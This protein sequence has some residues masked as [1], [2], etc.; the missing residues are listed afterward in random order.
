MQNQFEIKL[1]G[2]CCWRAKT[3]CESKQNSK[4]ISK[5]HI[6]TKCCSPRK[7]P[8]PSLKLFQTCWL[9]ADFQKIPKTT[10]CIST[11]GHTWWKQNW[12]HPLVIWYK[13]QIRN[14]SCSLQ[15]KHSHSTQGKS[16][17]SSSRI[18]LLVVHRFL[19]DPIDLS[20]KT[21]LASQQEA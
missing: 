7:R 9:H 4:L 8:Q 19:N 5:K 16:T 13:F 14:T 20:H 18:P 1:F 3:T 2:S 15:T 11:V 17:Y 6:L 12:K 10:C 21:L